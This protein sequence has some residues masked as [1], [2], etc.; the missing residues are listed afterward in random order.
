M[1]TLPTD[2]IL[3]ISPDN[4]QKIRL[5]NGRLPFAQQVNVRAMII[6]ILICILLLKFNTFVEEFGTKIRKINEKGR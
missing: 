5:I 2:T 3:L 6:C 4:F 1:Q